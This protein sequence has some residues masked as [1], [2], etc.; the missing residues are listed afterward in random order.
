MSLIN[1]EIGEFCVQA[2]HNNVFKEVKKEDVLGGW[3]SREGDIY[4][5]PR[6][7]DR[8]LSGQCGKCGAQ[9]CGKFS[10]IGVSCRKCHQQGVIS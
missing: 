8:G 1:K 7:K 10:L 5:Q 9:C 2:Y 3:G 6:R 4:R